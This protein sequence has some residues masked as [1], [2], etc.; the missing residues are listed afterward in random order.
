MSIFE[1]IYQDNFEKIIFCNDT[2]VGLKAI[3]GIHNTALGP[4]TGG[5]RMWDYKDEAE[6]ITDVT[7]LAKG[8]SYK[9]SIS[10]L[11]MG[12]GKSVIIGDPA[13]KTPEML[14]RF[15]EFVEELGGRYVT[16][17]DVG[18]NSD[19]LKQMKTKT[20][21]IL[22]VAGEENSS[23][24]PSP[25]TAWG[26][27]NG[28]KACANKAF[29]S[30]SLEGKKVS[31]QGLGAVNYY[32]AKHLHD[33]GAKL[34]GCDINKEA[35]ERAAK[36]FGMEVV[37][38]E[39]IYDVDCDIFSPGA[40]GEII[41]ETTIPKLKCKV[42]AGAANNQLATTK[43]GDSLFER[44]MIYAPDYAINAGG[45]INIFH[46]REGYNHDRAWSHVAGI[47]DTIDGILERSEKDKTPEYIVADRI[48]QERI[49]EA[50]QKLGR[51]PQ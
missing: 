21:N 31:L 17:K 34:I 50:E 20:T 32:L 42:V 38:P 1:T 35:T 41:N 18:I 25:V 19:D 39:D 37:N 23:G 15:G 5:C 40:L 44:G 24:D 36:E 45:L 10:K 46:E 13:N 43:D 6:A 30:R 11:T 47:Y 22:G 3:I 29:G 51:K 14:A 49:N 2:R 4:A 26:V 48:A 9:A 8:M 7:R 12:G 33:D 16:A 27:F 28:M